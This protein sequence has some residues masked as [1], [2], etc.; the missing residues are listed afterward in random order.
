MNG[1]GGTALAAHSCGVGLDSRVGST[2]LRNLG[3]QPA[4]VVCRAKEMDRSLLSV[5]SL[6]SVAS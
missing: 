6:E 4:Y 3:C 1:Y 5:G 2:P